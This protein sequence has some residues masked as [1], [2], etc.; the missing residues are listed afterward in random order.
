MMYK[1]MVCDRESTG[2]FPVYY[3]CTTPISGAALVRLPYKAY[4][5]GKGLIKAYRVGYRPVWDIRHQEA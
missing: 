4:E 1:A 3:P 2:L 5:R